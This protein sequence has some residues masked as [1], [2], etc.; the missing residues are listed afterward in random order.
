MK[1]A[2]FAILSSFAVSFS[3]PQIFKALNL[4]VIEK[5]DL[6]SLN[7]YVVEKNGKKIIIYETKDRRY[8]IIGVVLDAK[9]G[10]NL[11]KERYS[12]INKVDF[13]SIPLH[14]AIY[15]R[16]GKGG[17]KLVMI[18]DPDC[19]FCRKAHQYLKNKNVDLYVFLYPLLIHPDAERKSKII[20]CSKNP[21]K[22]YNEVMEGKEIRGKICKE[23]IEKLNWHIYVGQ[24]VGV[25]G[26]PTFVFENGTKVEGFDIY[27]LE[28]RLR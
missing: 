25:S 6:G 27:I 4:K 7:E 8:L 9:T 20:L 24:F 2:I 23:G 19:P 16:F 14:R 26:T 21:A 17:T 11:T 18:S 13:S 10:R 28:R 22:V 15:L 1:T 5:R 3:E 12:Q